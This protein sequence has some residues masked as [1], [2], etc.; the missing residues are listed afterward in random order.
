[1]T[2]QAIMRF[3]RRDTREQARFCLMPVLA[4]AA[5]SAAVLLVKVKGVGAN[6]IFAGFQTNQ[7][8]AGFLFHRK[9]VGRILRSPIPARSAF[10][11]IVSPD[12]EFVW[13]GFQNELRAPG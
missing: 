11:V 6:I 13:R 4:I 7:G 1:M 10:F 12:F 3:M 9:E 8:G 5:Q 2:V